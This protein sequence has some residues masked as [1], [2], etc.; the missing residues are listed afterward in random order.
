M[1]I[2]IIYYSEHHGN[3]KKV[4]DA[5]KDMADV[6]LFDVKKIKEKDLIKYDVIGFA[7]GIYHTKYHKD[8]L[9]FAEDYLPHSQNVF[10]IYTYGVKANYTK[11]MKKIFKDKSCKL[12]GS[13]GCRGFDTYGPLKY[14]GG[15][16]KKHPNDKDLNQA[17]EY[18]RKIIQ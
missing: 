12:L 1:K 6:T 5:I 13:F 17:R 9:E 7:S 15:I 11:E 16:A 8:I 14:I 18:F 10:L 2:A 3:T 4:L